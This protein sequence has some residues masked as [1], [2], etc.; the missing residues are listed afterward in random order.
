MRSNWTGRRQIERRAVSIKAQARFYDGSPSLECEITDYSAAGAR[1]V[2]PPDF[3]AP[4]A[5]DVFIPARG[6]TLHALLRWK[7]PDAV[8]VEFLQTKGSA[9]D[10]RLSEL[11]VR[12]SRIEDELRAQKAGAILAQ[13]N[14]ADPT[15]QMPATLPAPSP[16]ERATTGDPD[17]HAALV[18]RVERLE[19]RNEEL[20]HALKHTLSMLGELRDATAPRIKAA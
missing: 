14:N 13:A 6:D 12:V 7:T 10:Q 16:E 18:Q 8:G 11:L 1:I 15:G 9:D 4:G 19:Q 2:F 3:D 17:D 5:F 20:L